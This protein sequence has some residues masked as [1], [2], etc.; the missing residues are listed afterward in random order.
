MKARTVNRRPAFDQEFKQLCPDFA[1][2]EEFLFGIEWTLSRHPEK[3][4]QI[5]QGSPVWYMTVDPEIDLPGAV[6]YYTFDDTKVFLMSIKLV[7]R[8]GD[9]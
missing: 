4:T 5:K 1:K 7:S 9:N 3:G 2:A 8:N 6:V